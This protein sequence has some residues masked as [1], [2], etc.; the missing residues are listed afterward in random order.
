MP[1]APLAISSQSRENLRQFQFA[2]TCAETK[3]DKES[4]DSHPTFQDYS[5]DGPK[6]LHRPP[7]NAESKLPGICPHTPASKIPLAALIENSEDAFNGAYLDTTPEDHVSWQHGPRSS[8]LASSPRSTQRGKKRARSSSPTS[9]SQ[10]EKPNHLSAR[11]EPLD[12]QTLHQSLK[13]PQH[14]PVTDLWA[15]YSTAGLTK[16]NGHNA[17]LPPFEQFISASPQTPNT[18]SSKE[19]GLQRSIS[20]GMEWPASRTK[21]RK[22]ETVGTYGRARDIFGSS[23]QDHFSDAESGRSR[24]EL[25]VGRVKDSMQRKQTTLARGPSSSSPLPDQ[26]SLAMHP[27][28]SPSPKKR[29]QAHLPAPDTAQLQGSHVL[30]VR[31]PS[32]DL[33]PEND[34]SSEFGDTDLDIDFLET[35]EIIA[36]EKISEKR[37]IQ[38]EAQNSQVGSNRAVLV[39]EWNNELR[40]PKHMSPS[41]QIN[42]GNALQKAS[43]TLEVAIQQGS[44]DEFP[45]EDD[46]KFATDMQDLVER[47]DTQN[48]T[49][50]AFGVPPQPA[51]VHHLG[52]ALYSNMQRNSA[53]D[54]CENDF[55]DDDDLWDEIKSEN[56][57]QRRAAGIGSSSQVGAFHCSLNMSAH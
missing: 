33:L 36:N 52:S 56:F 14:D 10:L 45:I 28:A 25:L 32:H 23:R 8:D 46:A 4:I 19:G 34:S 26:A 18:T 41:Q 22:L 11:K 38:C 43:P 35:V 5:C 7:Q 1:S 29:A 49:F 12:L 13:T 2:D 24:V 57:S 6:T 27:P 15:R 9:S 17:I 16:A 37:L 54:V 47:Y 21:R 20:C 53:N 42:V 50:S 31:Q 40:Q 51:D 3:A 48:P 39:G 44:D 30:D 55:D